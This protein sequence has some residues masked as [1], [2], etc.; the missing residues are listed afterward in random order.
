MHLFMFIGDV[1][2]FWVDKNR[3]SEDLMIRLVLISLTWVQQLNLR[4]TIMIMI[5]I[6][7]GSR[8]GKDKSRFGY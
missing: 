4:N 3:I 6:D 7:I 1:D 2:I 8:H 5:K